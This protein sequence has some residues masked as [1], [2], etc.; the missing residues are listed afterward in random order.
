M[1]HELLLIPWFVLGGLLFL[2]GLMML[3]FCLRR[4]AFS[5]RNLMLWCSLGLVLGGVICLWLVVYDDERLVEY[6]PVVLKPNHGFEALVDAPELNTVEHQRKLQLALGMMSQPYQVIGDKVMIS[7][8]LA[9]DRDTLWNYTSRAIEYDDPT[10][11]VEFDKQGKAYIKSEFYTFSGTIGNWRLPLKYPDLVNLPGGF[12]YGVLGKCRDDWR[13]G[14][15]SRD[16]VADNLLELA[17]NEQYSIFKIQ[18]DVKTPAYQWGVLDFKTGQ[19]RMFSSESELYSAMKIP[20]LEL[21]PVEWH[22]RQFE[23]KK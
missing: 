21:R 15:V 7:R 20:R 1:F 13:D 6:V 22:Y 8:R 11:H 16:K 14:V 12:K 5:C 4:K 2:A 18:P 3:V 17:W 19:L 10:N 23:Q 9:T